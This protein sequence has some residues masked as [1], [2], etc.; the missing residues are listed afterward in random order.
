MKH[1]NGLTYDFL[2]AMG[3]RARGEDEPDVARCRTKV[4]TSRSS[5][6]A[7][8]HPIVVSRRPYSGDKYC[9]LLH[10][11]NLELKKPAETPTTA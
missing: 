6:V 5:C 2:Y 11:S 1:I 3:E 7:V 10:L 9:L 4:K 8:A